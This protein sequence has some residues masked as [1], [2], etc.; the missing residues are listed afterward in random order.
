[1]GLTAMPSYKLEGNIIFKLIIT[2]PLKHSYLHTFLAI[3]KHSWKKC[4]AL[5]QVG[6]KFSSCPFKIFLLVQLYYYPSLSDLN[7]SL[8]AIYSTA[9]S[10]AEWISYWNH[11]KLNH[12]DIG[13]TSKYIILSRLSTL[14]NDSCVLKSIL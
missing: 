10:K 4:S 8:P 9:I 13:M 7:L 14:V 11:Q 1:M 2:C 5:L 12:F 3:C 6:G